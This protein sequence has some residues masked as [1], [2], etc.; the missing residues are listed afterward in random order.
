MADIQSK[1]CN[2]VVE[3]LSHHWYFGE[4]E[5]RIGY[6]VEKMLIKIE[7]N[8]DKVIQSI[9]KN[10]VELF[11]ELVGLSYVE[12]WGRGYGKIS[13]YENRTIYSEPLNDNSKKWILKYMT[14][15]RNN[16]L[17]L[18]DETDPLKYE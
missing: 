4:G 5:I 2:Q 14:K 18:S 13:T 9:D 15:L 17:R 11:L 16:I 10:D 8:F 6:Y 3:Y 12:Y 7:Q 1:L